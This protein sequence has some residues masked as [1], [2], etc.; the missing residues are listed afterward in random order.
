MVKIATFNAENLFARYKFRENADPLNM[1]GFTI[2][3]LAFDIYE[4]TSKQITA[5]A[6]KAT[7][8]DVLALQEVESLPVLDRFNSRYLGGRGYKHRIV[9]DAFD[10]RMIDVAVLSKYPIVG[11]KT[12]RQERNKKN[13]AFLFS[14]DCLQ[15]TLDID[16]KPLVMYVNHFKSMIPKRSETK[17]RRQEQVERVASIV[18]EQWEAKEYK[19]N[20]VVLGDFN[21]Y[22]EGDTSLTA[23]INH[24][25]LVNVS[26]R[27]PEDERWTHYWA[28]GNESRQLDFILLSKS[29]GA[30]NSNKPEIMRK[31]LPWRADKYTG[32]RLDNVGEN[33]PKASDHCPLI[34]D[35]KLS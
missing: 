3:D 4:E 20:F 31:G 27:L 25:G 2:N 8:A 18:K 22:I 5:A 1:E 13:S 6:V 32:E 10:P 17:E 24:P 33:H 28:G 23:L 29:L 14:R 11:V 16:G 15:V 7:K 30:L 34:M 21:D 19:G 12:Y 26:E 9:I 35:L